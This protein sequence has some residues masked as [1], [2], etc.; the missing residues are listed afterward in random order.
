MANVY[1]SRNK[2]QFK[3]PSVESKETYYTLVNTETG[4]TTLKRISPLV[5]DS[6][7]GGFAESLD[8]TVGTIPATGPNKGK[9][10]PG[11]GITPT[12]KLA[13]SQQSQAVQQ[14][15]QQALTTSSN[16]QRDIAKSQGIPVDENAIAARSNQL[17]N[18]GV[19]TTPLSGD[20]QAGTTTVEELTS[21]ISDSTKTGDIRQQY[22]NWRYPLNM[23]ST[24]D[25]I[26]I[27]MYRYAKKPFNVGGVLTG[28][29]FG[30]RTLGAAMGS[31]VLPIQPT[32]S[33]SNR[34][35]WG[36]TPANAL[37]LAAAGASLAGMTEGISGL[38][39][40][41]EGVTT[42]DAEAIKSTI[43]TTLAGKAGGVTGGGLL[44]RLTGGILNSNLELLF[45]GPA[46]RTFSFTFSMSAREEKEAKTIRNIIRF[47]K[48]GMS[49]KRAT[50]N[51][52]IM[53]PNIFTI[54]YYYGGESTEHPWINKI[55]EC[56]LTD[57]SVNYTPAGNYATYADGAM[58]Q[59]DI[60]L[61]FSELDF[62]YDDMYGAG[63]GT[64]DET[65][66]GY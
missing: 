37:E 62:L 23:N 8:A 55:K 14:V 32:I 17:Q 3:L 4:E 34:V 7:I 1:G 47:F 9:F 12:E 15:K 20:Q 19:T 43:A 65:T 60:T 57:C 42:D 45:S 54:K 66:I 30:Q 13:F 61:N 44:T 56:A 2:N 49:V 25:R 27:A 63:A 52:F 29:A 39:K 21:G 38:Q 18:N 16:A 24:Q 26:K 51:L 36:G 6:P 22:G 33:D 5:L 50:S 10:V 40:A 46:L 59:Y 58:T 28:E 41:V 53:S 31:V 11:A 48:Q 35:E 64:G